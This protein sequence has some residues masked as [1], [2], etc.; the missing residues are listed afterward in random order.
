MYFLQVWA[1]R[2]RPAS[3]PVCDHASFRTNPW[4]TQAFRELLQ[5]AGLTT[6]AW[7]ASGWRHLSP[8]VRML[9]IVDP[10]RRPTED[11]LRGLSQWL[12]AGGWLVVAP[13]PR[14]EPRGVRWVGAA[15]GERLLEHLGWRVVGRE[16]APSTGLWVAAGDPATRDVRQ[17]QVSGFRLQPLAAAPAQRYVALVADERGPVV[18]RQN[19]GKGRLFLLADADLLANQWIAGADNVVLAANLAFLSPDGTVWFEERCHTAGF[20]PDRPPLDTT[21]PG[22]VIWALLAALALYLAGR[23]QRFGEVYVPPPPPRRSALETVQAFA[24]LYQ[25]ARR[26]QE[27]LKP[28]VRRLRRRLEHL[29]GLRAG[30]DPQAIAQAA[31]IRRPGL[32]AQALAETLHRCAAVEGGAPLTDAGLL[33]LAQ[34]IHRAEKELA[35]HGH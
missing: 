17:L 19:R 30:A 33:E 34:R 35:Q 23:M 21:A 11:D 15:A 2:R 3:D 22:R 14:L 18:I 25:R 9:W 7:N 28:M 27:A 1:L 6:H 12:E 20:A 32:D 4:G 13:D 31:K 29:T 5:R 16:K 24:S 8:A 10:Q 26:P